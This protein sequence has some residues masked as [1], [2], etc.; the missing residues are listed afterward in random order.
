MASPST[1]AD[2]GST[3]D[4][5][6]SADAIESDNGGG[7]RSIL[8]RLKTI[9]RN[10]TVDEV[11]AHPIDL[12]SDDNPAATASPSTVSIDYDAMISYAWA[13][14]EIVRPLVEKLEKMS[15]RVWI[16]TKNM[17]DYINESMMDG[18][19]RS[20]MV[21]PFFSDSYVASHNCKL[22]I[23]FANDI[24]KPILPVRLSGSDAVVYSAAAFITAGQLYFDLQGGLTP[25][26][27]ELLAARILKTSHTGL[28]AITIP[29]SNVE[30]TDGGSN[31]LGKGSFAI[32]FKGQYLGS[33]P[34]AVKSIKL[35]HMSEESRF[36]LI[37]EAAMLQRSRHP[38]IIGFL[39]VLQVDS[40]FSLVLEFAS[41]GSL[42]DYYKNPTHK[43]TS[44][45]QRVLILYQVSAGMAHLHD[46]LK[47]MHNDLKSPN[48]LLTHHFVNG[49]IVSKIT[50]FGLSKIKTESRTLSRLS[51]DPPGGTPS[52]LW[53]APER[54]RFRP[55]L[56][57]AN[58]V[59]SFAVV[60]T[61][62]VSWI[63]VYGIPWE[64]MD[65]TDAHSALQ[66]PDKR[67][68]LLQG[69][70]SSVFKSETAVGA[71]LFQLFKQCWSLDMAE[72]PRFESVC[73]ELKSLA[74]QLETKPALHEVENSKQ[75]DPPDY[76]GEPQDL[77]RH[78]QE[79]GASYFAQEPGIDTARTL[80]PSTSAPE[81]P[82][83]NQTSIKVEMKLSEPSGTALLAALRQDWF[84]SLL[85]LQKRRRIREIL[86]DVTHLD[87]YH[88]SAYYLLLLL[89]SFKIA[90]DF[91]LF[92]SGARLIAEVLE[93]SSS[94]QS[95]DLRWSRLGDEGVKTIADALRANTTL[96][97][98]NLRSNGIGNEGAKAVAAALQTS[99]SLLNVGLRANEISEE[100]AIAMGKAL[101]T[102]NTLQSI[103]LFNNKIGPEGA[104][105]I[106]SA[107]KTNTSMCNLNLL[108]NKIAQEGA[109]ALAEALLTNKTLQVLDLTD[110]EIGDGGSK[111][112]A[113]V[114]KFNRH[115]QRV[116]L[117]YNQI[118]P[119]GAKAIADALRINTTLKSI[120]LSFNNFGKEGASAIAEARKVNR[121]V[122]VFL[123]I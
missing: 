34:V 105:A 68:S 114:L 76:V 113:N 64:G 33:V 111:A 81:E 13:D 108:G 62:V 101:K 94:L 63:G 117:R 51:P 121:S 25:S 24:R 37:N 88:N 119:D 40:G 99:S 89:P 123:L 104:K 4:A 90:S 57:R 109:S 38:F 41:L 56:S 22:E 71:A 5:P 53:I 16:D 92:A 77:E 66:T 44:L 72:R 78:Q 122:K 82:S 19:R 83:L 11:I 52:Q 39:G 50:D 43:A 48:I 79:K 23:K 3:A 112:V 75:L 7:N 58:D 73:L 9:P 93:G 59:Y 54:M 31:I 8:R 100:G 45:H 15:V 110:N 36:E 74:D 115:L 98:I 60:M 27:H 6:T 30:L 18:I 85:N 106:A 91:K 49:P 103:D 10:L 65:A 2:A 35:T 14:K 96:Q 42:H 102:N 87:L 29:T 46:K 70:G 95:L 80:L 86:A 67:E 107:L 32:V 26:S 116:S 21:V 1:D 55:K 47:I 20:A 12:H 97:I 118:S 84:A 17:G 120:D 61:E 69:L 28:E